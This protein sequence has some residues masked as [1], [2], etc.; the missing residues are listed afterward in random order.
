M[1]IELSLKGISFQPLPLQ[2]Y[3]FNHGHFQQ[4]NYELLLILLT[5]QLEK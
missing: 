5:W 1:Q 2:H 3:H 4:E